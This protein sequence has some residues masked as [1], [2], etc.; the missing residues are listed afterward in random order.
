VT[1]VDEKRQRVSSESAYL[2]PD[3]LA[4]TNLSVVINS[5]A[6]RIIFEATNGETRAVGVEYAEMQ[7]SK[8]YRVRARKE[9]ILSQVSVFKPCNFFNLI[10]CT[11]NSRAGAVHTPSLLLL[12]GIGPAEHLKE[13]DIPIVHDLP[14]VGQN[15]VDHPVID[16][17]FKDKMNSS[18]LFLK[19]KGIVDAF[20]LFKNVAQYHL[21][22]GGILAM[23]VGYRF[24]S[25]LHLYS[26]LC[27]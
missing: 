8:R 25:L 12:S 10:I 26:Y 15:L 22:L 14:G 9:V 3:V 7:W 13:H 27:F 4:R 20:R 5:T 21:G 16:V 6:T 24:F 11:R 23:N 2:T 1:Y 18:P 17:S 19:P